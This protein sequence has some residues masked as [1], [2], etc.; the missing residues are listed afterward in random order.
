[1]NTHDEAGTQDPKL[2]SLYQQEMFK[3][4]VLCF[5]G[6]LM[7]SYSHQKHD[8]DSLV[9]AFDKTCQ[10]I[11]DF[12]DSGKVIDDVLE[13][14]PGAPVFKGLRERNAVSN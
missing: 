1:M 8:L 14:K 7:L 5:S 2:A 6:V 13:C 11:S 10:A 3:N 12:F 9:D 4:G